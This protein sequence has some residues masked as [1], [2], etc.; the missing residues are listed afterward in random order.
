V[1]LNCPIVVSAARSEALA[2][3][4]A[5]AELAARFRSEHALLLR[6]LLAPAWLATLQQLLG[7]A[8]FERRSVR[9]VGDQMIETPNLVGRA[10]D[11]T[12]ARPSMLTWMQQLT[13]AGPLESVH[14][15]VTRL[16]AGDG[17]ELAWH[18]DLD[19]AWR[20]LAISV[21]LTATPF[22]GG[23]FELRERASGRILWRQHHDSPGDALV[24][25]VDRRLEHRV[26]PVRAGGPRTVF[27]GW[28]VASQP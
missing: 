22:E 23:D 3:A 19:F 16:V 8:R 26:L 4:G 13:G 21:A 17:Q 15:S 1:D 2:D 6:G 27:A 10:L 11:L 25:R 14:G 5:L 24:F 9:R 20:P 28:F 7:R 18:D 12:L